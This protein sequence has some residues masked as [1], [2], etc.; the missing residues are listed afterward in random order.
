[1]G[2][3]RSRHGWEAGSATVEHVGLVALLAAAVLAVLIVLA[4]ESGG[5][6][7][8]R[9]ASTLAR[10]IRCAARAPDPCWRDPLTSAYG[11]ALA[12]AVRALAPAPA[13]AQ[14]PSGESQVGVDYRR[15][16]RPS[17]AIPA[18][19]RE[20]RLTVANRRIAAFTSVDDARRSGGAVRITYWIYRPL[21]AWGQ[22]VREASAARIRALAST[23]L[24]DSDA[25]KL[26]PLETLAGRNHASF[27][28]L[29]EPPWRWKV[30]AVVPR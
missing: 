9:L 25:P 19:G 20:L 3:R 11:R 12:G 17:C 14:G 24:L 15:C 23:P 7:D 28:A 29:E 21:M 27:S 18:P 13:P 26:I 2:R 4:T 30:E 6:E 5:S 16:R 10:K 1:M 8:R 22:L